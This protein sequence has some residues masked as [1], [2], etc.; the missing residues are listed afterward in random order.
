MK[1]YDIINAIKAQ[2][3]RSAWARGVKQIAAD[4]LDGIDKSEISSAKDA[5]NGAD[6]PEQWVY[7]GCGL[8]Y[9][10]DIAELLCTPSELRRTKGGQRQP[11]SC[12][13]WLDVYARAAFQ[14][15]KLIKV[16]LRGAASGS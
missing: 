13:S 15:Y 1:T 6:S 14:A 3:A 10:E 9:D 8:I 5:L 2:K 12:E 7:G 11:N 16:V 4:M